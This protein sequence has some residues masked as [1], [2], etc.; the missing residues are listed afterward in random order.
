[1][2]NTNFV[3]SD[4]GY[5]IAGDK[6]SNPRY[7]PLIDI[8]GAN[9]M[10]RILIAALA[11]I[12]STSAMAADYYRAMPD[13]MPLLV[14]S[15]SNDNMPLLAQ[16]GPPV[17]MPNI[18]IQQPPATFDAPTPAPV[19][20]VTQ[21]TPPKETVA[22]GDYAGAIIE[23]MVPIL[24]P[25]IAAALVDLYVKLR[26]R[27]GLTTSDAQRAKFQEIVENGVAL[28]AHD[29]QANLSGKLTYEVKNQV[30]A[31]AVAY[32]KEHGS[33]TLKAIGVDPTSPAAEEAIRARAAKML[34]NLDA[35]ATAVA[36][37]VPASPPSPLSPATPSAAAPKA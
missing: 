11:V 26:A 3:W 34:A 9:H 22:F 33:D 24:M 20:T 13:N 37:G 4:Y 2:A 15:R 14:L 28:G 10:K 1:M 35:A 8:W 23:W 5:Q 17:P 31:S 18:T 16:A 36:S 29:A 6:S 7:N 12:A 30:M 25:L 27:L 21:P 19:V 32:A